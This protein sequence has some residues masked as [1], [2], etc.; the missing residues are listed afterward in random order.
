[1]FFTETAAAGETVESCQFSAPSRSEAETTVQFQAEEP[2]FPPASIGAAAAVLVWEEAPPA[3]LSTAR[4]KLMPVLLCEALIV[5]PVAT[6]F[7]TT[8]FCAVRSTSLSVT[9]ALGSAMIAFPSCVMETLSSEVVPESSILA[10]CPPVGLRKMKL[11]SLDRSAPATVSSRVRSCGRIRARRAASRRC[12]LR[13]S[14]ASRLFPKGLVVPVASMAE[15]LSFSESAGVTKLSRALSI[16]ETKG[17]FTDKSVSD[18]SMPC[19]L[20]W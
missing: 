20:S 9:E 2:A 18:S 12:T 16:V 5:S 19:D 7:C 14:W 13:L 8:A 4:S 11:M 3:A 1:M 15:P 10:G 17:S 6:I